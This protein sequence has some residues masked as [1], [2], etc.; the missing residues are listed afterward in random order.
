V[1]LHIYISA[2]STDGITEVL[3]EFKLN[4]TVKTSISI[5]KTSPLKLYV[6]ITALNSEDNIKHVTAPCGKNAQILNVKGSGTV[7]TVIQSVKG[8]RLL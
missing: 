6:G 3:Y 2:L 5:T 1:L 7:T 4:H 8:Q